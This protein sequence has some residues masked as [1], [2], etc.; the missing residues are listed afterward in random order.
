MTEA[1]VPKIDSGGESDR[2]TGGGGWR[3]RVQ[4][5]GTVTAVE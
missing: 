2:T 3:D 1:G 4:L 5:A